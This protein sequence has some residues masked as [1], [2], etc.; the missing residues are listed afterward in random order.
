MDA[1]YF[2][3][4]AVSAARHPGLLDGVT[5]I[6]GYAGGD[7]TAMQQDLKALINAVAAGGSTEVVLIA[8]TARALNFKAKFSTSAAQLQILGSAAVPAD[9]VI[10]IDAQALVHGFGSEPSFDSSEETL[11]HLSNVPLELVDA[12]AVKADPVMSAW[13]VGAIALRCELEVAFGKR[14]TNAVAYV[15]GVTW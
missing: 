2:S 1:A 9:R 4:D 8:S 5:A 12:S 7:E 11:L 14:R 3:A 15:D 6:A 10:A 13:Q